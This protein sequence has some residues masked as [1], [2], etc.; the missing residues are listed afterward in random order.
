MKRKRIV[1]MGFMGSMPIAGVIWQHVHYIVGLQQLGHE[2]YYIEDSAR[3]PYNHETFEGNNEFDYA[4]RSRPRLSREF[5]FKERRGFC[6]RYLAGNPTAGL[7]L[8]KIRQ[9]Y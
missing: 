5:E 1:V 3:L 2:V 7:A 8:K 6:A 9:L 4:A